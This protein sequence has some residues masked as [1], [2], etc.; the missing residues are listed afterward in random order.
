MGC[1]ICQ[2]CCPEN[3][4]LLRIQDTGIV[5][6]A[7]ETA[8]LCGPAGPEVLAS[9]RAKLDHLGLLKFQPVL[10]RN[11]MALVNQSPGEGGCR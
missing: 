2:E 6:D 11:L 9:V 10:G 8:A 1:L 4:G 7:A 3:A 5:F